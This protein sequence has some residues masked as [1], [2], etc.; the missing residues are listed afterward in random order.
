MHTAFAHSP[1]GTRLDYC[2]A[3]S[4]GGCSADVT[5]FDFPAFGLT[6]G[7]GADDRLLP[8]PPQSG[9]ARNELR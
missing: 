3:V 6:E 7:K 4:A 8:G 2:L 9:G 1:R 5:R